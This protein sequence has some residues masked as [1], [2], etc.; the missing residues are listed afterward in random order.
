M[1]MGERVFGS[2][3]P[4]DV[5]IDSQ[6]ARLAASLYNNVHLSLTE[7]GWTEDLEQDPFWP[8][9][10]PTGT[11]KHKEHPGSWSMDAAFVC[12]AQRMPRRG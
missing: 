2:R 11:W 9:G 6:R 3:G 5:L 1:T 7:A 12:C 4:V 8:K 10:K